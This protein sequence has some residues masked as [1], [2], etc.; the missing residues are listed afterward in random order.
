MI[1]EPYIFLSQNYAKYAL[2]DQVNEVSLKNLEIGDF[3]YVLKIYLT[4]K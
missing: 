1:R 2:D 4:D 3:P